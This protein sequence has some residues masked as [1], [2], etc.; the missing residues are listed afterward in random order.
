MP[1]TARRHK[2]GQGQGQGQ[3]PSPSPSGLEFREGPGT[4]LAM[5]LDD[6]IGNQDQQVVALVI[7]PVR[8]TPTRRWWVVVTRSNPRQPRTRA[9]RNR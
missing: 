4:Q 2:Q 7:D 1:T 8:S 3:E 6:L 9:G 5:L